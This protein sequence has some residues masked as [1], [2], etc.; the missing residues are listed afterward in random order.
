MPRIK[1]GGFV[2]PHH[3]IGENP[4]L[5]L[6]RDLELAAHLDRLGFDEFWVGEHHSI[7]GRLLRV[8]SCF[9]Q[10]QLNERIT[11]NS[12]QASFPYPITTPSMSRNA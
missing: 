7:N 3:P 1:F 11:L 5:Q 4:T 6:Q 9:L 12:A 2:A 10:Q 8:R